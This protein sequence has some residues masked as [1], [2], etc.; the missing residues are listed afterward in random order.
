MSS[1]NYV[2]SVLRQFWDDVGDG[3]ADF[4]PRWYHEYDEQGVEIVSARRPY[5][6]NENAV[7]DNQASE[8]A[9]RLALETLKAAVKLVITEVKSERDLLDTDFTDVAT[10][11]TVSNPTINSSPAKY[12]KALYKASR[13]TMSAV[14]DLAKLVDD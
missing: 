13:R 5:D 12:V 6:D 14:V 1:H 2:D 7:A 11:D 3:T 10:G 9:S 4:P 8:E